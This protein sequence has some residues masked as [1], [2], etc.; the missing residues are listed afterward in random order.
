MC[1]QGNP[2]LEDAAE[3]VKRRDADAAQARQLRAI[4]GG[5]AKAVK[6]DASV[7]G[8]GCGGSWREWLANWYAQPLFGQVARISASC[9]RGQAVKRGEPLVWVTSMKLEHEL[10]ARRDGVVADVLVEVGEQV[11][12]GQVVVTLDR[13]EKVTDSD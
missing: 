8:A 10:A 6:R 11:K 5:Q 9:I 13:W 12:E 7:A 1:D 2:G 3:R 4:A